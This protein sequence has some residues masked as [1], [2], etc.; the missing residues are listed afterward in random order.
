MKK[1]LTSE[2]LTFSSFKECMNKI[3]NS[4]SP[5]QIKSLFEQLKGPDNTVEVLKLIVNL[6]GEHCDTVDFRKET[7][8]K[9]SN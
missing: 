7:E 1:K 5:L 3:D 9:I 4:L 8:K 2:N 6:T